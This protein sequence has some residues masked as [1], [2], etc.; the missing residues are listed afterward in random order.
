MPLNPTFGDWLERR[1]ASEKGEAGPRDGARGAGDL[2]CVLVVDDETEIT[3]SV[4]ELLRD[5]YAVLTA[6]SADEALALLE[7]HAVA[8]ILTDQRMPGGSGAELLERALHI[9]PETTRILFSGY[10]DISVVVDAVNEG[11]VFHYLAKPWRPEELREVLGR[12]VERHQILLENR[13]LTAEREAALRD[14]HQSEA[15]YR[16]LAEASP[17]MVYVIGHDDTVQY[18]NQRAAETVRRSPDEVVGM[19]RADLFGGATDSGM[20]AALDD[21]LQAGEPRHSESELVCPSGRTWISTWLVPLKDVDGAVTAVLGISRDISEDKRAKDELRKRA[22]EMAALHALSAAATRSLSLEGVASEATAALAKIIGCDLAL[23]FIRD[24]ERLLLTGTAPG[25]RKAE[26]EEAPEHRVGECLCGLAVR[27]GAPIYSRDLFSDERCTLEECKQA[28]LRSFAALPLYTGD[29]IIG[30]VGVASETECDFEAQAAFLETLASEVALHAHNAQLFSAVEWQ[31][32]ALRE[33]EVALAN[34]QRIAHLGSWNWDAAS[35]EIIWSAE[36]CRIFGVAADTHP[37][38]EAFIDFIHPD[39]RRLMGEWISAARGGSAPPGIECRILRPDGELRWIFSDGEA[40][41]EEAGAVTR[42]AGTVLDVTERKQAEEMLKA[43]QERLEEAHRLAHIGIWTWR[44]ADDT[45]TWSEELYRIAGR[46]PSSPAPTYAEHPDLYA[47]ESWDRLQAAVAQACERGTD[48]ELDLEMMRP[49]GT[50]RC[51]H[52]FGGATRNERGEVE[53][54]YGTIQDITERMQA[55]DEIRRLNAE[56][57]ERVVRR[58]EQLDATT[59]ELEA[60]AYSVAH[61]VRAPLRTIDGFSAMVMEDERERLSPEGQAELSRVRVAAQTLARL[62]DD[63]MGLSRVSRHELVREAVDLSALARQVG[64]ETA[65]GSPSRRVELTVQPE[66]EAVADPALVRL[67]LRELLRNAWKFTSR[68]ET[69]CI[70]VGATEAGG[71][72]AFYVRD[73]GA[74][75]DMRH[76]QHLFGAFQRMHPAGEFEGD[77]IG[78]ATVQR[79]VRRHGGRVWAEAEVEKGATF[80]F[81]L[82]EP[83]TDG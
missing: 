81:T 33:R 59:R 35:G 78:L 72:A 49:D 26:R 61:D 46:D 44:V 73:D 71:E 16:T 60:F 3:A 40:S 82:P 79:L 74:G 10:S 50:I 55:E 5:E 1:G 57:E 19:P 14:L 21:V 47:P 53:N 22:T 70:E 41:S 7:E 6:S 28:G 58:T 80:H 36:A 11:Q 51:V 23:V 17:D 34:A 62:L 24:G 42:V 4:A 12:G 52:V 67:I 43:S 18:L 38:Q 29:E 9:A 30:A 2:P 32:E 45:V 20:K 25:Y 13:A 37:A 48:Y 56:L 15:H 68:H 69:A 27:E 83:A 76:A 66:L 8:A 64:E 39:D 77:G 65:A 75:F 54:L 63:L 31:R